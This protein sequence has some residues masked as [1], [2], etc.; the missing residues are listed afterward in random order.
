MCQPTPSGKNSNLSFN[1]SL[2]S[3]ACAQAIACEP[4]KI[5]DD[6]NCACA[7]PGEESLLFIGD[8]ID[9]GNGLKI[10]LADIAPKDG[11]P[12]I[13]DIMDENGIVIAQIQVKEGETYTYTDPITNKSITIR[14]SK[15]AGGL[16]L[17]AKWAVIEKRPECPAGFIWDEAICNCT[18]NPGMNAS[19][20]AMGKKL[21]LTT[22]SCECPDQAA[23]STCLTKGLEWN[24]SNCTCQ[25]NQTLMKQ[26]LEKGGIWN[27]TTCSCV[28]KPL[29]CSS[30]PYPSCQVQDCPPA[31]LNNG[32]GKAPQKCQPYNG[33]CQCVC[34][35]PN[36]VCVGESGN[37]T[38][39][40]ADRKC[41]NGICCEPGLECVNGKCKNV[42]VPTTCASSYPACNVNDCKAGYECKLYDNQCICVK[43]ASPCAW[44]SSS[45]S[46]DGG[47]CVGSC[48]L[49]K[50]C[51]KKAGWQ[52]L[53]IDQRCECAAPPIPPA[54]NNPNYGIS[55]QREIGKPCKTLY[56]GL[57]LFGI[58]LIPPIYLGCDNGYSCN[59]KSGLCVPSNMSDDVAK[60][61]G[62]LAYMAPS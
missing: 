18:C 49:G 62:A 45:S 35:L 5:F 39:C 9:A 53:S 23:K 19:C 58:T 7:C 24:E 12:A 50:I 30:S 28:Y 60:N 48:S 14:V 51:I 37:K 32:R 44:A 47:D 54:S 42:T 43:T 46:P 2:C 16:V 10:R 56:N 13:I 52:N 1:L 33:K 38:C 6:V 8:S 29:T 57:H 34:E 27:S 3:C 15:T 61:T 4:P 31:D 11:K 40:S 21:N 20:E 26:C 41:C 17:S 22:C 55:A 36:Y 59:F 25:C